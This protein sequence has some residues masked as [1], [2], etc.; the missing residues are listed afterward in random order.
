MS[1]F[2]THINY[3]TLKRIA[4]DFHQESEMITQIHYKIIQDMDVLRNGWS[5]IAA[6]N[7]FT[8]MDG[9]LLPGVERLSKA[10]LASEVS[11]NQIAKTIYNADMET[12]DYYKGLGSAQVET[13][14]GSVA[15]YTVYLPTVMAESGNPEL[16]GA[17]PQIEEVLAQIRILEKYYDNKTIAV[18]LLAKIFE[19]EAYWNVVVPATLGL[20]P[21]KDGGLGDIPVIGLNSDEVIHVWPGMAPGAP[22]TIY[23]DQENWEGYADVKMALENL[24]SM[25]GCGTD[26]AMSCQ[27]DPKGGDREKVDM[28][29]VPGVGNVHLAH[30]IVGLAAH[31]DSSL[32]TD[33][34][35]MGDS[36]ATSLHVG[37]VGGAVAD[38]LLGSPS[39]SDPD[40]PYRS[41]EDSFAQQVYQVGGERPDLDADVD[42][43]SLARM[44]D[45]NPGMH[46]SDAL[47]AYYQQPDNPY[48]NTRWQYFE[49]QVLDLPPAGGDASA[50]QQ[51]LADQVSRFAHV[52]MVLH[53]GDAKE[54][55]NPLNTL[56]GDLERDNNS[57]KAAGLLIDIVRQQADREQQ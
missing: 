33:I 8:E 53:S 30:V 35:G 22:P 14:D 36:M 56:T 19:P 26:G 20:G 12:V 34:T 47:A 3:E 7:F 13:S 5:G 32:A 51:K 49:Q 54:G 16:R 57:Y 43:Y 37:D 10:L 6:D 2:I 29:Q 44:L 9:I 21:G 45:E 55:I 31:Y 50:Q 25:M 17:G 1:D 4:K 39:L 48:H 52:W 46:I 15:D 40:M 41:L 28:M 24:N 38:W 18:L 23:I 11:L 42:A 27:D